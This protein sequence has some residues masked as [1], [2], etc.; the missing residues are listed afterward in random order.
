MGAEVS[1][2]N[3]NL[4]AVG[5]RLL[6]R[7]SWLDCVVIIFYG[8]WGNLILCLDKAICRERADRFSLPGAKWIAPPLGLS[9]E[10]AMEMGA[11]LR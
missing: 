4:W 3:Y 2:V 10:G 6:Y 9:P 7:R 1:S 8:W 11:E 5:L